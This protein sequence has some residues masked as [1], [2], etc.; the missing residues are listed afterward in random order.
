MANI[1]SIQIA[2]NS[3]TLKFVEEFSNI[4]EI[5]R[6]EIPKDIN[7]D[8]ITI[9]FSESI[10]TFLW[11]ESQGTEAADEFFKACGN[12]P[13]DHYEKLKLYL[14][15][16]LDTGSRVDRFE[17]FCE[18][19]FWI[20]R[21]S[22]LWSKRTTFVLRLTLFSEVFFRCKWLECLKIHQK[23]TRTKVVSRKN[24]QL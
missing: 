15:T 8:T 22:Y 23:I 19:A 5:K 18:L 14:E 12:Y 24:E 21:K 3:I 6:F 2:K 7:D 13:G 1:E 20:V 11:L 10:R 9:N 16:Q 4:S 17:L